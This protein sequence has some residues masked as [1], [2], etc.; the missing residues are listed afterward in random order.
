M[1]TDIDVPFDIRE[2]VNITGAMIDDPEE[3]ARL[4]EHIKEAREALQKSQTQSTIDVNKRVDELKVRFNTILSKLSDKY[5]EYDDLYSRL[6]IEGDKST[7]RVAIIKEWKPIN[8]EF[9]YDLKA[10]Q[11]VYTDWT[12]ITANQLNK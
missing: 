5:T 2:E 9:L 10:L 11:G 8:A 6:T 7:K 4:A 12:I 3:Q 1:N